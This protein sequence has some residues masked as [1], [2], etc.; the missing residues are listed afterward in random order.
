MIHALHAELKSVLLQLLWRI[1]KA[2]VV[3]NLSAKCHKKLK[4]DDD[5][6]LPPENCYVGP[7]TEQALRTVSPHDARKEKDAEALLG[8]H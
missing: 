3:N 7:K 6:L 5:I 8:D 1:M 2:D 4:L